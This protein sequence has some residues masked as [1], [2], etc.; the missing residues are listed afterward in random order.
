MTIGV[1]SLKMR[2]RFILAKVEYEVVPG[3]TP[4]LKGQWCTSYLLGGKSA[5]GVRSQKV[6]SRSFCG[7]FQGTE[8][9]RDNVYSENWYHLGVKTTSSHAHKT[10]SWYLLWIV[11]K[12]LDEQ[13]R[14]MHKEVSPDIV[15]LAYAAMP[16]NVSVS[17]AALLSLRFYLPS[18]QKLLLFWG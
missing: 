1:F 7:A 16:C 10:G 15:L 2:N 12:I 17:V 11:F 8:P 13:P 6:N 9:D 14:P 3:G 5:F 4:I 18:L